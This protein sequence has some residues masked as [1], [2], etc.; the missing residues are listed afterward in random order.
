MGFGCL[1]YEVVLYLF[2]TPFSV[3][4]YVVEGYILCGDSK[5]HLRML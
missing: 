4:E 1:L 5:D 3:E 2:K